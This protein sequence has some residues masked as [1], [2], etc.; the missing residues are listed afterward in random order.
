[1]TDEEQWLVGW[2]FHGGL[3]SQACT[4]NK[5]KGTPILMTPG[6]FGIEGVFNAQ[7]SA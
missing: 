7:Y 6:V 5:K 1:M 4:E 3:P 2:L